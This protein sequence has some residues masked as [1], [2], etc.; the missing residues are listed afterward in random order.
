M[1]PI[2]TQ[3]LELRSEKQDV[4]YDPHLHEECLRALAGQ[5]GNPAITWETD[6]K[7][8]VDVIAK[9]KRTDEGTFHKN[10]PG[11]TILGNPGNSDIVTG[12]LE[13]EKPEDI[14]KARKEVESLKAATE[15]YLD[16]H[17]SVQAVRCDPESLE[18]GEGRSYPGLDGSGVVIGIVD[19]GCD[20]RHMSFRKPSGATRILSLWDQSA[21]SS[22]ESPTT[23]GTG[24][25]SAPR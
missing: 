12:V 17:H 19:F 11:L 5:R 13:F 24:G 2:D 8:S 6:K 14:E 9:L 15:L 20:F 4:A 23:M 25:R 1:P 16:L 22:A 7:R 21:E 18:V 3:K 10:V